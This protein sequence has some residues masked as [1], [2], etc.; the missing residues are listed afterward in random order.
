MKILLVMMQVMR[1]T[2]RRLYRCDF[3]TFRRHKGSFLSLTIICGLRICGVWDRT[4]CCLFPTA[5][6]SRLLIQLIFLVLRI[7][8]LMN[9]ALLSRVS[10]FSNELS[11]IDI[12]VELKQRLLYGILI[13][14]KIEVLVIIL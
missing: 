10:H 2:Q 3:S 6:I 8:T 9:L 12:E 11:C 5:F 7:F 13:L 1:D 4:F 14:L